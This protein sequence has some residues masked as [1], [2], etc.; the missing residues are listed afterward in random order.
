MN[1]LSPQLA[2]LVEYLDLQEAAGDPAATWETFQ[3]RHLKNQT[4]LAIELKSRQ[5]GWSW[6]AAGESVA[7]SHIHNNNLSI[8]ISINLAEAQEKIR[9]A[10]IIHDALDPDVRR[11]KV[12]DNRLEIEYDNGSRIISHPCRPIRGKAKANLYLDEFAHYPNDGEIYQSAL[13]VLSK[14]GTLR[15]GSSPLGAR[16]RFWEIYTQALRKYPGYK[17]AAIPWWMVRSFCKDVK[18]AS[19]LAPQ[20]QTEER[21][22]HFGTERIIQIYENSPLDDFQQE[23]EC[24][25]LDET[26]SWIDWELIKLNQSLAL[27]NKLWYRMA[28]GIDD[29]IVAIEEIALSISQGKCEDVLAGGFD[30]G[31]RKDRSELVL[32]GQNVVNQ[33]PFRLNISLD[34]VKFDDQQALVEK[35]MDTLPIIKLLV[36]ET[37]M[38]MQLAE[39]LNALYGPR[40][41]GVSFSNGLKQSL[42]VNA[43]VKAQRAETPLPMERNLTYQIHSVKRKISGNLFL[44]ENSPSDPHHADKFWAWALA[45]MAG[46]EEFTSNSSFSSDNPLANYRG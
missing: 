30:V 21:V 43:K 46:S 1:K 41:E 20:M 36:D 42:A 23:Y 13:P 28:N 11:K 27:Q 2:F 14:G 9:Y 45:L 5:V 6:L 32:V 24:A 4:L 37:G 15:I 25:W 40:C 16:G 22:Y 26:V 44:F 3:L 7:N 35:A 8:F 38:G 29:A 34:R 19:T 18:M 39:N 12:I 33:L 31:R 17:R 10:N